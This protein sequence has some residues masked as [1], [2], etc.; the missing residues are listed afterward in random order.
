M[1]KTTCCSERRCT[2]LL[3]CSI[4]SCLPL[5]RSSVPP[6][7]D[8][9][10][11]IY[12]A[13]SINARTA[14]GLHLMTRRRRA[15]TLSPRTASPIPITTTTS[16]PD[17]GSGQHGRGDKTTAIQAFRGRRRNCRCGKLL[18]AVAQHRH[19]DIGRTLFRAERAALNSILLLN[20]PCS[21]PLQ[22]LRPAAYLPG[23][24]FHL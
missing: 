15:R 13:H 11:H 9:C 17:F 19:S 24:H 21:C 5:H 12:R 23:L 20:S 1:R 3:F 6:P 10:C 14:R 16:V 22:S 18:L 8:I 7:T 4:I 2:P